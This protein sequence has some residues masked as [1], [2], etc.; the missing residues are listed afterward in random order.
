METN[1]DYMKDPRNAEEIIEIDGKLYSR[2]RQL[3][4]IGGEYSLLDE[5]GNKKWTICQYKNQ[6]IYV[7]IEG[8][9]YHNLLYVMNESGMSHHELFRLFLDRLR[10]E[11]DA[12]K[13]EGY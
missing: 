11:V 12:K 3:R 7:L 10:D 1:Q 9:N 4:E 13:R 6:R 5:N 2:Y 8:D